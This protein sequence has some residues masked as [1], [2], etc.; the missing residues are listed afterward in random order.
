[1]QINDV[2]ATLIYNSGLFTKAMGEVCFQLDWSI[3]GLEEEMLG[4]LI[5][6]GCRWRIFGVLLSM[7]KALTVPPI[8]KL[9]STQDS[10]ILMDSLTRI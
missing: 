3:E 8:Q 5:V 4:V 10:L 6:Q 7:G 1:M 2:V 9:V